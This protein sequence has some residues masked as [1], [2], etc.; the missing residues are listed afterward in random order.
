MLTVA[1]AMETAAA[2]AETP[3]VGAPP[4]APGFGTDGIVFA[5]TVGAETTAMGLA[6]FVTSAVRTAWCF[7]QG[8]AHIVQYLPPLLEDAH[9]THSQSEAEEEEAMM[10]GL[11]VLVVTIVCG[12]VHAGCVLQAPLIL[13]GL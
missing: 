10:G 5:T 2:S 12:V 7:W 1:T 3:T 6:K 9:A 4:T 8:V 13:S 11:W